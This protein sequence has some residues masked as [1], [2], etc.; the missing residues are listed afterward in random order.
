M[1]DKHK[2]MTVGELAKQAKVSIRTLQYYDKIDLLKPTGFSEGGRRIYSSKDVAVLHQIITLKSLGF[3]LNDI[4]ERIIPVN[5]PE[6]AVKILNQQEKIISEKIARLQKLLESIKMLSREIIQTSS[7]DWSEYAKMVNLINENNEF[8]WGVKQMDDVT[9]NRLVEEYKN[10]AE[11][12]IAVDWWKECSERAMDLQTNG[13]NPESKEGEELAKLWWD[14]IMKF[15]SGDETLL[16]KLVEFHNSMDKWPEEYK[17]LQ[18]KSSFF[19]ER[20]LSI[21]IEKNNIKIPYV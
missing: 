17:K 16:I 7:I 4:K 13:I 15:T 6:D 2:V 20:A 8:Y 12:D 18:E 1:M 19:I 10:N 9:L 21:Y 14:N 3:S 11:K 5:S